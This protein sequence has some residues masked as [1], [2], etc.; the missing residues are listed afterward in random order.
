MFKVTIE[1]KNFYFTRP[2]FDD[3]FTQMSILSEKYESESLNIEF[4]RN[5]IEIGHFQESNYPL[6]KTNFPTLGSFFRN[7][8][9]CHR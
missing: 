5:I 6:K 1:N 9:K 7:F 4:K 3:D 2:I 8:I